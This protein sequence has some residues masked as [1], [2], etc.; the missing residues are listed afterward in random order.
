MHPP[1]PSADAPSQMPANPLG[2]SMVRDAS[3]T[4]WLPDTSPMPGPMWHRGRLMLMAHGRVFAQFIRTGSDRGDRQFGSVNWGMGMAQMPIAGGQLQAR[5]MMSAEPLTVGRCGYPNLA[6]TGEL[7]FLAPISDRQHPHDLF[8]ELAASYRRAL[9]SSLAVE[10]YGGPAGSPALGPAAFPHRPSASGNPISPISHHW[11]DST[12][13]AFGVLTGG[14]YGRAWKVEASLFNGR[15]P[16]ERR[17]DISLA[18]LDSYS[19]RAWWLPT[20]QLA[21]QVSAG[22]LRES[23]YLHAF[24]DEDKITASVSH[25][26]QIDGRLIA[27]TVAWGMNR[28]HEHAASAL[29]GEATAELTARDVVFGRGEIAT[30]AAHELNV[31]HDHENMDAGDMFRIGKIQGGYTR[32]LWERGALKA[33][34]GGSVGLT[35]VPSR[36]E[37]HYGRRRAGEFSVFATV[38]TQ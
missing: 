14:V 20:P 38:A 9:G 21:I 13:I 10:V 18:P 26:R 6:Q 31:P 32:W 22:R 29:V 12:H 7:C 8:M 37:P 4:S 23:N 28:D 35:L 15:E 17:Y 24:E 3:G 5:L 11:L 30:K 34:A 36:L 19:G 33:G 27:T 16:N 25:H 2:I 1:A